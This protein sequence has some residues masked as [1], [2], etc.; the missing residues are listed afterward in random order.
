[1]SSLVSRG[2]HARRLDVFGQWHYM[3]IVDAAHDVVAALDV[4]AA[5]ADACGVTAACICSH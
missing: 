5:V 3:L 4:A 2:I 1:M